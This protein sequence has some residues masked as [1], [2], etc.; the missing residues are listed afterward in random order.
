MGGFARMSPKWLAQFHSRIE[1]GDGCHLWTHTKDT[2]GYG[3]LFAGFKDGKRQTVRAHRQAWLL[4]NGPITDGLMV[5]HK[6][7]TP[8]CCRLDHLELGTH[9][10]NMRDRSERRQ[11]TYGRGATHSCATLTE[12]QVDDIR[13]ARAAGQIYRVIAARYGLH[14]STIAYI[15]SGKLWKQ[16][17]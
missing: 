5:R 16:A 14:L 8:A 12:Q 10:D 13:A 17:A 7:D 6:C 15:C 3:I 9:A 1:R 2:K 11:H 4:A